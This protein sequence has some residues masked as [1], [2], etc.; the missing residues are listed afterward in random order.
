MSAVRYTAKHKRSALLGAAAIFLFSAPVT[1]APAGAAV[2]AAG[3]LLD[4]PEEL[5]R[6]GEIIAVTAALIPAGLLTR[7]A[8]FAELDLAV[9]NDRRNAAASSPPADTPVF[10]EAPDIADIAADPDN[11]VAPSAPRRKKAA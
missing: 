5:I 1:T 9:E 10:I 8:Y 7:R 11:P 6:T 2:W 3:G 4:F